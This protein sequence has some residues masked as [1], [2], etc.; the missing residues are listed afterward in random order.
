MTRQLD[1]DRIL[2]GFLAEGTEE[3]AD[4]V[5]DAALNDID[6]TKQRRAWWPPQRAADMNTA[7]R[8]AIAAAAVVVVAIVAFNLLP[9]SSGPGGPS[10]SPLPS[11]TPRNFSGVVEG[12]TE[13]APGAYVI[14]VFP[15]VRMT[16]DVPEGWSKG[17]Y[18]WAIFSETAPLSVAFVTVTDLIADPCAAEPRSRVPELGTSVAA[19]LE[20]L[21]DTPGIEAGAV[22]PTTLDGRPAQRLE[23]AM[24]AGWDCGAEEPVLFDVPGREHLPAPA[25]GESLPLWLVDVDGTRVVIAMPSDGAAPAM[26]AE[27]EAIVEGIRFE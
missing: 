2:D 8:L 10:P 7:V 17:R 11:A 20:G 27:A 25:P 22:T 12:G 9:G 5:L 1:I 14:T 19:L 18:D 16:I 24:A 4:R 23:L 6:N 21:Q 13:L 3:L 26:V 15:T